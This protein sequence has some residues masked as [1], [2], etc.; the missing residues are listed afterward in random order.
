MDPKMFLTL[1]YLT[2]VNLANAWKAN[3]RVVKLDGIPYIG[4]VKPTKGEIK[5]TMTNGI[6]TDAKQG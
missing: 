2:A 3:I 5:L 4:M 1:N 6:I